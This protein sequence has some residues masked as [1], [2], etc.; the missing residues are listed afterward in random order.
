MTTNL[1]IQSV[2]TAFPPN[3]SSPNH[4]I[5]HRRRKARSAEAARLLVESHRCFSRWRNVG[6]S[7]VYSLASTFESDRTARR[8]RTRPLYGH[9][10]QTC[11]PFMVELSLFSLP[12]LLPRI[13][14]R[15]VAREL[16]CANKRRP[17]CKSTMDYT[18]FPPCASHTVFGCQC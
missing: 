6:A 4:Y 9:K 15:R 17:L 8:H 10:I 5:F 16:K 12:R 3:K 14:R 13:S 11:P 18:L 1:S 7:T 2:S